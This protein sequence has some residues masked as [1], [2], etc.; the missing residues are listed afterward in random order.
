MLASVLLIGGLGTLALRVD[1]TAGEP[2]LLDAVAGVSGRPASQARR[3]APPSRKGT[4]APDERGGPPAPSRSP[5]AVAA[6]LARI[7]IDGRLDDWPG[8]L[9]HYP[10]RNQLLDHMAYDTRRRETIPDPDS[11]FMVGYDARAGLICVAV[12]VRDEENILINDVNR[13]DDR[14]CLETDA[15]E[16]FVNAAFSDRKIKWPQ[17]ESLADLRAR[18]DAARMPVLQYVG[19]PGPTPAY[20]DRS[21]ANPSM[22][23]G[24]IERTRTVM[25]YRREGDVT[26]YE[27]AVQAFDQYPDRPARLQPGQR[28]GFE[29]AIVD[30]DRTGRP[31]YLTWAAVAPYF[32]G[33]DAGTLGE[34]IL[35]DEP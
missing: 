7:T 22:V 11:Y 17:G 10:I 8:D 13:T 6:P 21:G 24:R 32:K 34:L 26:T 15:V 9:R 3:D 12:V 14:V 29:V 30:K 1:R 4:G 31:A 5:S 2:R 33:Y 35:A 19:V 20:G 28:L 25:Q 23:Y 18:L 27:W 16:I